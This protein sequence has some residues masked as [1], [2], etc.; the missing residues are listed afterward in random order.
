[1]YILYEVNNSKKSHIKGYW[2]N[3]DNKLYIDNIHIRY[4]YK[5]PKKK[6]DTLLYKKEEECIFI[7]EQKRKF[8]S[9]IPIIKA[10]IVDKNNKIELNT[11]I[12]KQYSIYEDIDNIIIDL[13]KQYD[14]ITVFYIDNKVIIEIWSE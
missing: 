13:L 5:Y 9:D 2:I 7:K 1:M 3:K 10:F 12:I 11:C 14:G 8:I 6:I 4:S